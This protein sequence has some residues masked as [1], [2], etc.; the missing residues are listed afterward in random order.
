MDADTEQWVDFAMGQVSCPHCDAILPVMV[1]A[2]NDNGSL[3]LRPNLAD[4]WT[5]IWSEHDI[6]AGEPE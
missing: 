3:A 4:V 5:H 1:E 6:S 2:R